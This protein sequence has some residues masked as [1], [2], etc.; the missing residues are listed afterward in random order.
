MNSKD[1]LCA[2]IRKHTDL[3]PYGIAD[4]VLANFF[5]DKLDILG[6]ILKHESE[7]AIIGKILI[8]MLDET[9][10]EAVREAESGDE[11]DRKEMLR[12]D[13]KE[14]ARGHQTFPMD[15]AGE[16]DD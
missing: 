3:D 13:N 15:S 9:I 16:L 6:D 12:L 7:P 11:D 4:E 2:A 5:D 14:R 8:D 1:R 10:K